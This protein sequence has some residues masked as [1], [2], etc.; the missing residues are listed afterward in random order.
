MN[1]EYTNGPGGFQFWNLEPQLHNFTH[2]AKKIA[3]TRDVGMV[4]QSNCYPAVQYTKFKCIQHTR[5]TYNTGGVACKHG[6]FGI[7]IKR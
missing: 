6:R 2:T 5:V 7:K 1:S 4:R 3:T